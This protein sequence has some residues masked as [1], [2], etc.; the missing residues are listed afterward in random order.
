MVKPLTTR[1]FALVEVLVAG[2]VLA[3]GMA[4]IVSIMSQ[5]LANQRRGEFAVAA[6]S[7]LDEL[8]SEV[9]LMGPDEFGLYRPLNGPCEDPWQDFTYEVAIDGA[10][11]PGL[12]A[13]VLA[14]VTDPLGRRHQCETK[15]APRPEMEEEDR[16]R[17]PEEPFDREQRHDELEEQ[18]SG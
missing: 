5:S 8:L 13:T 16:D 18:T 2:I 12:P 6:A 10:E 1:G 17:R 14:T 3:I 15:V 11:A 4:A 7:I 9:V